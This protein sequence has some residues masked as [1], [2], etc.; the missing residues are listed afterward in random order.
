VGRLPEIGAGMGHW[1]TLVL[2]HRILTDDE[3]PPY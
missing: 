3:T 2:M 1:L